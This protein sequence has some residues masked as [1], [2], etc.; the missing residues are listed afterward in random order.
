MDQALAGSDDDALRSRV[1]T[2]ARRVVV[3]LGTAVLTRDGG[4]AH[5]R[6]YPFAESVAALRRH[7]RE[8]LLVSSGAVGL[9]AERLGLG[10]GP[11]PVG[12]R[13]ACAAV[14]QGRLMGLWSEALERLGLTAAQ[15]LL[16]EADFADRTRYL[17]LRRTIGRLLAAGVVP[18]INEN[19][20]VSTA[21]LRPLPERAEARINFGDNDRLSALVAA[22]VDADLLVLLTDVDGL[23]TADPRTPGATLL[24]VVP[25]V[26]PA[27]EAGAGGPRLG[28]GGMRT[29]VMAARIAARSGCATVIANGTRPDILDRIL[30]GEPVGTLV[31]PSRELSDRRRWIAF[32]TSVRAEVVVNAGACRALLAGKASLLPVGVVEIRGR[33]GRGDVVSVVDESG[34]EIARGIVNYTSDEA[35]RVLGLHSDRATELL[36]VEDA[37]LMRRENIAVLEDGAE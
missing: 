10:A 24:P 12:L 17:N 33:F 5:A 34:R 1:V 32:A 4:L 35:R 25:L 36:G 13:Q 15:L 14:G 29:K 19:D 9:G 2:G 8:V 22:K 23:F 11:H 31:L 18:V 27:L 3:K 20:T 37:E 7:G 28:T 21:E 16:T 30:A 6:L 26:T